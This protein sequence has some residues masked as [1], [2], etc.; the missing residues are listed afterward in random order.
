VP[1]ITEASANAYGLCGAGD[2]GERQMMTLAVLKSFEP[3]PNL[4]SASKGGKMDEGFG[5]S[6]E[7]RWR[8]EV[9]SRRK[10]NAAP[11]VAPPVAE[12]IR[13]FPLPLRLGRKEIVAYLT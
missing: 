11:M 8:M 10:S 1:E 2:T 12:R 7:R 4:R 9:S 3:S 13:T 6:R 5:A